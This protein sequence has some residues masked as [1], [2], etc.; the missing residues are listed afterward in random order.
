MAA[1]TLLF[2]WNR[3][4]RAE[5]AVGWTPE[6]PHVSQFL[7]SDPLV[8]RVAWREFSACI[9]HRQEEGNVLK[10]Q[11][12]WAV[13]LLDTNK[14]GTRLNS[15]KWQFTHWSLYGP[16]FHCSG[17]F[18]SITPN[19]TWMPR[20][21]GPLCN[22][23]SFF[24]VNIPLMATSSWWDSTQN[25]ALFSWLQLTHSDLLAPA[26]LTVLCS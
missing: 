23:Y 6:S 1:C 18:P 15:H 17:T 10:S 4:V 7:V 11:S 24:Q 20:V 5:D 16:H 14:Y 12:E 22:I 19:L 25:Q 26:F 13:Q 3:K 9:K 2:I 21:K 8:Y